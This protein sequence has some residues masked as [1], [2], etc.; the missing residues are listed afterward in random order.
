MRDAV[1]IAIAI[2]GAVAADAVRAEVRAVTAIPVAV[3]DAEDA[4][5]PAE[6]CRVETGLAPSRATHELCSSK[7]GKG[8]ALAV[9]HRATKDG[10]FS[11]LRARPMLRVVVSSW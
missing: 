11:P 10:G 9:P 7:N 4:R 3:A 6:E 1:A 5:Q 8:T 2:A